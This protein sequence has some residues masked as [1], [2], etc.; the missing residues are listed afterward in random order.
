MRS[1]IDKTTVEI[2]SQTDCNTT[3]QN[4]MKSSSGKYRITVSA[5]MFSRYYV[6]PFL[7]DIRYIRMNANY[8]VYINTHVY[9]C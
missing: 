5:R 8:N 9:A 3:A 6:A 2:Q 1:S 4:H 7:F